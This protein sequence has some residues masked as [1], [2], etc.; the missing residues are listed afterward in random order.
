[1]PR[2]QV[3]LALVLSTLILASVVGY[4]GIGAYVY[5]QVTA[6]VE[7]C[8]AHDENEPDA[9]WVHLYDGSRSTFNTT[10][11]HM[12]GT[13]TVRID[14]PDEDV[15]LD[16]WWKAGEEGMP[17][18]IV[19]HGIRSCKRNHE[20]LLPASML[21]DAGYSVLMLTPAGER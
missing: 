3:V 2:R 21:S 4:L 20:V 18:V 19:V 11:F 15:E 16:A 7:G 17:A 1:M 13:E 14:V 12:N 6:T 8:G 9:F 10:P 5:G